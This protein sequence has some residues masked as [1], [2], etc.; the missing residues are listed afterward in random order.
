MALSQ[1]VQESLEEAQAHL[2]TALHY[3]SRSEKPIIIKTISDSLLSIDSI[4][5]YENL[6][7]NLEQKFK[8][9]GFNGGIF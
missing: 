6:S 5:K 1:K 7:D 3:A 8:D 2:R 9:L 4:T